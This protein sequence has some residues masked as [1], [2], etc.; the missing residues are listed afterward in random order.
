M[1]QWCN[2]RNHSEVSCYLAPSI[3]TGNWNGK[4]GDVNKSGHCVR[5][6]KVFSIQ[7]LSLRA[8]E[9][10]PTAS[11]H[12]HLFVYWWLSSQKFG[13]KLFRLQLLFKKIL[14]ISPSYLLYTDLQTSSSVISF[15]WHAICLSRPPVS[16]WMSDWIKWKPLAKAWCAESGMIDWKVF[17]FLPLKV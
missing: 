3:K 2:G 15:S 9:I 10:F 8:M 16:V 13:L 5:H 7:Q 14:H 11:V 12:A 4:K 1:F 6:W 17:L